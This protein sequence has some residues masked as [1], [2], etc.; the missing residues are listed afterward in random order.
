MAR[1]CLLRGRGR[2]NTD[3]CCGDHLVPVLHVDVQVADI[4]GGKF[5]GMRKYR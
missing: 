4:G 3:E 1:L 2:G 5:E